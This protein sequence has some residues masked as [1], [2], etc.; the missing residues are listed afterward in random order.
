MRALFLHDNFPA[1][2]G[3]LGRHMSGHG[4]DVYFG[5]QRKA[6]SDD[7]MTV[8]HTAPHRKGARDIHPYVSA[9]ERAV[10]NGQGVARACFA[11][12]K[13][14]WSPDVVM[15]H[16]GWG[17]GLF[18]KDV[19]PDAKY[20]GYFEWYY[21]ATAPDILYLADEPPDVDDQLRTRM[22]NGAILADLASCDVGICPTQFQRD[23]FPSC[24][25]EKLTVMHD[26]IDTDY[27]APNADAYFSVRDRTFDR[28]DEIITYV[29]RG[30]EPY[31]GFPEFMKAMETVLRERPNAHVI[32]VGE[33][34]VAYG[35]KLPEG[36]SY[37]KRALATCDLDWSRVHFTG[38]L[39]RDD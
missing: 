9:Y 27:H 14:G 12:K 37:K 28:N 32:V 6:A 19:W 20:V 15:A 17:P 34:R 38:L 16:S 21:S 35:R 22:R 24:F 1:Q 11:L 7:L 13:R 33:D 29:A 25:H 10:L 39:P 8:F 5:T 23:Q 30:M 31:R 36:D 26:G 3:A 4:W 18:I 2:F